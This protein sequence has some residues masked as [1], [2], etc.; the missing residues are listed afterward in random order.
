MKRWLLLASV[1]VMFSGCA[2][3][4]ASQSSCQIKGEGL[5]APMSAIETWDDNGTLSPAP[6]AAPCPNGGCHV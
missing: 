4:F 6:V 5:C 1:S 3:N 2:S